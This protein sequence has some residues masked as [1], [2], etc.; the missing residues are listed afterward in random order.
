MN[1]DDIEIGD[2]LRC[3]KA[4][5]SEGHLNQGVIYRVEGKGNQCLVLRGVLGS[6]D[7]NRF[8]AFGAPH[9]ESNSVVTI[10][11]GVL[12]LKVDVSVPMGNKIAHAVIDAVTKATA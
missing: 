8:E 11:V 2:N 1:F 12:T 4:G 7:V 10:T 5:G 9:K 6:W 3:V